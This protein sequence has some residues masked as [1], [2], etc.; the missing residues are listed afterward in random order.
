MDWDNCKKPKNYGGLGVLNL[1][2]F[3]RTLR[4][5]WLWYSWVDPNRPWVGSSVPCSEVDKQ[6]FRCCTSATVG[7]GR[8]AMFCDSS[9]V[10]GHAPRDLAPNLYKLAW[11]KGLKLRE[12]VQNQTWTRGLWRMS[13]ATGGVCLFVGSCTRGSILRLAGSNYMEVDS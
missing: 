12:E 1:E 8:T 7:D 13:I 11:R 4:L 3:S 2:K 9:W 10:N 5:R 6:F